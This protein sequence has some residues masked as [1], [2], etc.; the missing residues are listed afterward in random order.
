MVP[1]CSTNSAYVGSSCSSMVVISLSSRM[2]TMIP[3]DLMEAC[4]NAPP[5]SITYTT[6]PSAAAIAA[7]VSTD[8]VAAVG[9]ER[10]S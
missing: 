1:S 3:V 2:C 10:S 9:E 7:T 4:R 6:R 5:M 8:A